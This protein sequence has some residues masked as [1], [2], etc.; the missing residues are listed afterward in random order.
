MLSAHEVLAYTWLYWKRFAHRITGSPAM[1]KAATRES[2][3]LRKLAGEETFPFAAPDSADRKAS[4]V[5]CGYVPSTQTVW[6]TRRYLSARLGTDDSKLLV[7]GTRPFL[8]RLAYLER[9]VPE[10]PDDPREF[11]KMFIGR[12][13]SLFRGTFQVEPSGLHWLGPVHAEYADGILSISVEPY[14]EET[15]SNAQLVK[16]LKTRYGHMLAGHRAIPLPLADRYYPGKKQ[17][18][19]IH[20]EG[21]INGVVITGRCDH[22]APSFGAPFHQTVRPGSSLVI[23]AT[24]RG[25]GATQW[26]RAFFRVDVDDQEERRFSLDVTEP[27]EAHEDGDA[28]VKQP[29]SVPA[30]VAYRFSLPESMSVLRRLQVVL[31]PNDGYDL[32]F[33]DFAVLIPA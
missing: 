8:V 30:T 5:A 10:H 23:T 28:Y 33:S 27:E 13:E 3:L 4:A 22:D 2:T 17:G 14:V 20:Y 9:H 6:F 29:P 18:T 25:L 26:E 16:R 21:A 32:T 15:T 12:D 11:Q 7:D 24:V 31:A 19:H 1:G